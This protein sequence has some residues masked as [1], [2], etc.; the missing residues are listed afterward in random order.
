MPQ[1]AKY[2]GLPFE[3]GGS[4]MIVPPI[5]IGQ[6]ERLAEKMDKA[7]A[8]DTP[9]PERRALMADVIHEAAKR[10]YPDLTL[11]QV[12]EHF[13]LDTLAAAYEAAIGVGVVRDQK[14]HEAPGEFAPV[15]PSG[16]TQTGAGSAGA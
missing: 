6:A 11:D 12:K 4:W 7:G 2:S 1:T 14:T 16:Q 3:N 9:Y 8:K 15:D 13:S 5:S 10:N